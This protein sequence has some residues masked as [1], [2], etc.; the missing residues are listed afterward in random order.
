MRRKRK[1]VGES[2]NKVKVRTVGKGENEKDLQYT[3]KILETELHIEV[4]SLSSEI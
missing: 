1:R 4:I 2:E 3:Q